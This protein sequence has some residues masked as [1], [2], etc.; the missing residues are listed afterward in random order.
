MGIG[1]FSLRKIPFYLNDPAALIAVFQDAFCC[2]VSKCTDAYLSVYYV[3]KINHSYLEKEMKT[4]KE[5]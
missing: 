5:K 1:A 2:T 3:P 4:V